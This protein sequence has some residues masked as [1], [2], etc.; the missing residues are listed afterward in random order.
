M[1]ACAEYSIIFID[2]KVQREAILS[3]P[4]ACLAYGDAAE[5]DMSV[6]QAA[7]ANIGSFSDAV[8]EHLFS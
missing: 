7:Y 4:E 5:S 8:T 1:H 2:V 6:H 3:K